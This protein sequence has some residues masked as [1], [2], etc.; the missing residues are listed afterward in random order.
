LIGLVGFL[1]HI[2]TKRIIN[3]DLAKHKLELENLKSQNKIKQD[4]IKNDPTEE[5]KP[6]EVF[7]SLANVL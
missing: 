6:L 5:I 2:S 7:F 3:G 4:E 1:G